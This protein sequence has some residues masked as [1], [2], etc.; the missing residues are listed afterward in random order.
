M[1]VKYTD[2][3]DD[4]EKM[5]DFL[6]LSKELFLNCYSYLTEKEYELTRK[7]FNKLSDLEKRGLCLNVAELLMEVEV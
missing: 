3:I 2:F 5:L 7:R 6:T 4:T 1:T